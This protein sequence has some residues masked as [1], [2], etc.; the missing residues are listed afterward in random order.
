MK[1]VV[2]ISLAL[3]L[4]LLL[5]SCND[6]SKE[7][8]GSSEFIS[9]ASQVTD[10]KSEE[11]SESGADDIQEAQLNIADVKTSF[12][13]NYILFENGDLYSWGRNEQGELG[14]DVDLNTYVKKPEKIILPK[15]VKKVETAAGGFT[16]AA[17]TD[18]NEIF[19]WGQ[20]LY[21]LTGKN[22]G[23]V[24][25]KP[26]KVDVNVSVKDIFLSVTTLSILSEDGKIYSYGW[27]YENG[28]IV[29]E[30]S[31]FSQYA[32]EQLHEE[33]FP[34][35]CVIKDVALGSFLACFLDEQG[36]V[37]SKGYIFNSHMDVGDKKIIKIDF[38]EKISNIYANDQNILALGESG[39]L[40]GM[41]IDGVG[42][43]GYEDYKE[44]PKPIKI[45]KTD[46]PISEVYMVSSN[47]IV[48]TQDNKYYQWGYNVSNCITDEDIELVQKP[49][50]I[51]ISYPKSI[52]AGVFNSC[53]VDKENNLYAW[54][55][56]YNNLLLN[57]EIPSIDKPTKI[58]MKEIFI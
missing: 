25:K 24:I 58:N 35:D 46:K 8:S 7:K 42:I 9:S 50:E 41:G 33:Q 39:S 51:E 56:N 27:N 15:K 31:D 2:A 55:N 3:S 6:I 11:L 26:V 37:Y 12:S 57:E 44:Y 18:D 4:S 19:L 30:P 52:Y 14:L 45:E 28:P 21:N 36:N 23:I 38:P 1:K 40:Y 17:L 48:K 47:I 29:S 32:F 49:I 34:D 43:I 54:G 53:Y 16:A 13:A 5:V 10:S 20:N 22:S